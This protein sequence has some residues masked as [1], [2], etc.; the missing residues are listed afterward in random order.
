MIKKKEKFSLDTT[1]RPMKIQILYEDDDCIVINKPSGL[2]IHGDGRTVELSVADWV[3]KRYP[4]IATVGEPLRLSSGKVI[5]RQGIVHRLDKETSGVLLVAKTQKAY[6]HFKKQFQGRAVKKIYNTFVYGIVK[7]DT[8]TVA[9]PL[10]RSKHDFRQ[11]STGEG[12]GLKREATTHFIV[13]K[14]GT[15]T[16]YLEV[17]PKTGRTHQI[18]VHLKSMGHPVVCDKLYAK[19]RPCLLGFDR[20]ALHARLLAFKDMDNKDVSVEAPLPSDFKK[21][22]KLL[23]GKVV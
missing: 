14:R 4:K 18:R 8:G 19:S 10:S 15:M 9:L 21:A 2:I 23:E 5:V 11:F 6:L 13:L 12:K 7:K 3:L 1:L 16:S 20:L 22:I 17:I